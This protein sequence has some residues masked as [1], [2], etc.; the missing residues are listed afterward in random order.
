MRMEILVVNSEPQKIM[1][2]NAMEDTKKER[3]ETK[4]K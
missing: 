3:K 1:G 4:I 2:E